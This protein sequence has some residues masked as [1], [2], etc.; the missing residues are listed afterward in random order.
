MGYFT[1]PI[2]DDKLCG[3]LH[4]AGVPMRKK[5]HE[6]EE[7]YYYAWYATYGYVFDWFMDRGI[8]VGAYPERVSLP[9]GKSKIVFRP[10]VNGAIGKASDR[11]A[12][13]STA[14]CMAIEKALELI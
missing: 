4:K 11:V 13:W 6:S 1:Q 9:Y 7:K 8:Y 10:F 3:R 2:L 12:H 5:Q 14:A